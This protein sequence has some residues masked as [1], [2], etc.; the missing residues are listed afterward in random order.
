MKGAMTHGSVG[1]MLLLLRVLVLVILVIGVTL[2]LLPE[3][4]PVSHDAVGVAMIL[5]GVSVV[6]V[7]FL[8]THL[9]GRIDALEAEIASLRREAP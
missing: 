9:V 2:L 6:Q 8:L 4:R 1:T 3:R 7:W 5:L